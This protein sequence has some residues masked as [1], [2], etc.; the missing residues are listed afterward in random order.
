MITYKDHY[1]LSR[2]V[3]PHSQNS[4]ESFYDFTVK[5][6]TQQN[7]NGFHFSEKY[8]ELIENIRMVSSFIFNGPEQFHWQPR[9]ISAKDDNI[10]R[11]MHIYDKLID[12]VA[13]LILPFI[14]HSILF[15]PGE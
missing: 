1:A 2:L 15:G 9:H 12:Q 4:S 3:Y 5:E 10:I 6:F 13:S 8:N 7:P 11:A 14:E